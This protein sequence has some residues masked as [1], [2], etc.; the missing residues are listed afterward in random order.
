MLVWKEGLHALKWKHFQMKMYQSGGDS[1]T[2]KPQN[3]V[4]YLQILP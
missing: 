4:M 3:Y 2:F 1:I